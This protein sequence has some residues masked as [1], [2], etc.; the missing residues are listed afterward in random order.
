MKRSESVSRIPLISFNPRGQ[1]LCCHLSWESPNRISVLVAVL[2]DVTPSA[3]E[4]GCYTHRREFCLT[5]GHVLLTAGESFLYKNGSLMLRN[6][7]G[8]GIVH[9]SLPDVEIE[10]ALALD[11]LTKRTPVTEDR[12]N[13]QRH[14][15]TMQS[16]RDQDCG[17]RA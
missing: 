16:T 14:V 4:H 6:K 5:C 12:R 17:S 9:P 8:L 10:R 7:E 3:Q 2:E 11:R 13:P 1:I 15:A